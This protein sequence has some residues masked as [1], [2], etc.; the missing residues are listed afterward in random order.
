MD[1]PIA[2]ARLER[3]LLEPR[4]EQGGGIPVPLEMYDVRTKDLSPRSDNGQV[5]V[6]VGVHLPHRHP[7]PPLA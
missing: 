6:D 4:G 3:D 7:L 2:D 5:E 1:D